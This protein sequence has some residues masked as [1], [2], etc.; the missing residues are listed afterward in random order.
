MHK[1]FA[2]IDFETTGLS[3]EKGD[4]AI[5]LAIVTTDQNGS[6]ENSWVS[7]INPEGRHSHYQA[8]LIHKIPEIALKKAP[9]FVELAPTILNLVEGRII[10]AHNV[11]FDIR[12]LE[13]ELSR[14]R[15]HLPRVVQTFCTKN[16]AYHFLPQLTSANLRACLQAINHTNDHPHDALS[17]A[18]A[19][20]YLLQHYI[21]TDPSFFT[22]TI[23][24]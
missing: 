22:R 11:D 20:A 23:I 2:V 7:Y 5:Q 13:K 6:V 19:T 3:P 15:Y 10:T 8:A 16:N 21:K 14:T 24:R 17:D 9:H 18:E 4:R 1:G 12:F